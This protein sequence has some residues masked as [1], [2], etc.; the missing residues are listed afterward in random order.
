MQLRAA[1]AARALCVHG[2]SVRSELCVTE[3]FTIGSSAACPIIATCIAARATDGIVH[4]HTQ[5]AAATTA[6]IVIM[7]P[8]RHTAG[9]TAWGTVE[10]R[11]ATGQASPGAIIVL[12][13]TATAGITSSVRR[14]CRGSSACPRRRRDRGTLMAKVAVA[15]SH[16][17][18]PMCIDT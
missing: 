9:R 4:V 5:A 18:R 12:S 3:V 1:A 10:P 2:R 7:H 17:V 8:R 11:A 6:T 14:R 15:I 16:G 13:T